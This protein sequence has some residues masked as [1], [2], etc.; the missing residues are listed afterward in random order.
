MVESIQ[1]LGAGLMFLGFVSFYIMAFRESMWW[2]FA[3]LFVP[4]GGLFFFALKPFQA[5]I[6]VMAFL[7]GMFISWISGGLAR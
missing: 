5:A 6:P 2:G 7:T 3:C 4:L 1:M